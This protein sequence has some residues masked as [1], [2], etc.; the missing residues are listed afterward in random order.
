MSF[1]K[2]PD[3][4]ATSWQ[5]ATALADRDDAFPFALAHFAPEW[6]LRG[7]VLAAFA[8]V[9]SHGPQAAHEKAKP[10]SRVREAGMLRSFGE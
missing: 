2:E 5:G 8:L 10:A 1:S 9:V 6:G 7:I 3:S 4:Q